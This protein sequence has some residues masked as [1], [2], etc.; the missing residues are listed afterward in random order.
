MILEEG[1]DLLE[2]IMDRPLIRKAEHEQMVDSFIDSNTLKLIEKPER[3]VLIGKG[4]IIFDKY[5]KRKEVGKK[6]ADIVCKTSEATWVIEA[7]PSLNAE[8]IGQALIYRELYKRQHPHEKVKCG[9]VCKYADEEIYE[10]GKKYV[11]EI[12]VLGKITEKGIVNWRR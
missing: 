8:A 11:D 4:M 5:G 7:K 1:K 9:V 12:F 6:I 3:E 2:E 10:V